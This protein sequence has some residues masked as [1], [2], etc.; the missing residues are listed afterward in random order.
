MTVFENESTTTQDAS[1]KEHLDRNW[2]NGNKAI[3]DIQYSLEQF[4]IRINQINQDISDIVSKLKD[5]NDV[6]SNFNKLNNAVF[7]KENELEIDDNE[8]HL[9]VSNPRIEINRRDDD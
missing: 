5:L 8:S 2:N 4:N 3:N 7:G 6:V 9:N 1:Y